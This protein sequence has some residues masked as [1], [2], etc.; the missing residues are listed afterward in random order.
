MGKKNTSGSNDP[1]AYTH[2]DQWEDDLDLPPIGHEKERFKTPILE[3]AEFDKKHKK[4]KFTPL[5]L[6]ASLILGL[7][8]F[9]IFRKPDNQNIQQANTQ[10]N[11]Q[12]IDTE[13]ESN[14]QTEESEIEQK[15]AVEDS[16]LTK[17]EYQNDV[18]EE[19]V[20]VEEVKEEINIKN[21]ECED[22]GTKNYHIIVGSFE[23]RS[24][25]QSWLDKTAYGEVDID[26]I[27]KH[28]GWYR[29]ILFSYTSNEEA[30]I[31]IDF[32]KNDLKLKAW[33]AYMN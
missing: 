20:V 12:I 9:F 13:N 7:G 11:I 5:I 8:L 33:I 6:I 32:V 18:Q 19:A 30:E 17:V 21:E 14:N 28:N 2:K 24:Y 16:F 4:N 10:N 1:K 29:V 26:Y 25:A 15:Y 23:N 22:K 31:A 27:Q 3:K